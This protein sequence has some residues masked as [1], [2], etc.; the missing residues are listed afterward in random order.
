MSIPT[1]S[2]TL[3]VADANQ[4]LSSDSSYKPPVTLVDYQNWLLNL[5][6][7]KEEE[8]IILLTPLVTPI[9]PE[10]RSDPFEALGKAITRKHNRVRHIPYKN[11]RL[12]DTHSGFINL[13]ESRI[14]ILCLVSLP[15]Q[16]I[17]WNIAEVTLKICKEKPRIIV[18]F[19]DIKE[20]TALRYPTIIH[21]FGYSPSELEA[22]ATLQHLSSLKPGLRAW[23]VK[24]MDKE[25]DMPEIYNLWNNSIDSRLA[26]DRKTLS[27]ILDR[28]GFSKH[29]LIRDPGSEQIVG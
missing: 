16:S 11:Q 5:G 26:I 12:T 9:S 8:L 22:I 6:N 4:N 13:N 18:V 2:P 20:I 21:A 19:C 7:L 24:P 23:G 29:F 25:K 3:D 28:L 1:P 10:D 14:I 27:D 17:P 15:G